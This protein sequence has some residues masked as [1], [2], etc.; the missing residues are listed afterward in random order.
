MALIVHSQE[1]DNRE[2]A[3]QIKNWFDQKSFETKVI[4]G[5]NSYAIKARKKS[6][7]RAVVGADRAIEVAIRTTDG[8]TQV[9][10]RQGSWKT[11]AISNAA[12]LVVTGGMN[13]AIS[14]WSIMIQKDLENYIRKVLDDIGGF[15]EI[16]L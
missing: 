2:V 13:L 11:N 3:R 8:E 12:W 7:L 1:I 9:E 5:N 4:Q 6:K 15:Q 14:G 10:V 16:E